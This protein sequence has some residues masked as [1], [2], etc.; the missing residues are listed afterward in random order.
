VIATFLGAEALRRQSAS[1]AQIQEQAVFSCDYNGWADIPEE[2]REGVEAF[3]AL[4]PA[5]RA[6]IPVSLMI[7]PAVQPT[8]LVPQRKAA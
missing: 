7:R 8:D 5:P 3:E 6:A 1:S 4:P 2:E